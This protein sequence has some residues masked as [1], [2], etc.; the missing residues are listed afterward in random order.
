MGSH[1]IILSPNCV[2]IAIQKPKI[3]RDGPIAV[4]V[5]QSATRER[6]QWFTRSKFNFKIAIFTSLELWRQQ[7]D[8]KIA[9]LAR[10]QTQWKGEAIWV[11]FQFPYSD[12]MR[13]ARSCAAHTWSLWWNKAFAAYLRTNW[14][15]SIVW[16]VARSFERELFLSSPFSRFLS[17]AR[18]RCGI[19]SHQHTQSP[20]VFA[21]RNCF[22][23]LTVHRRSGNRIVAHM[24]T[25]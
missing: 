12:S 18:H 7:R 11:K 24:Q 17:S 19:E 22:L 13:P 1:R 2:V 3:Y 16:I 8:A 10:A 23:F 4:L 15:W 20:S 6:I 5:R 21:F 25:K 9:A 14:R